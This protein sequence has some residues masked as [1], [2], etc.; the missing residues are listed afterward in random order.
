MIGSKISLPHHRPVVGAR[1]ST[2]IA[3][4][5]TILF[6]ARWWW[7]QEAYKEKGRKCLAWEKAYGNLRAQVT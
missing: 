5:S 3:N 4:F 6:G 2:L 1:H 7:L